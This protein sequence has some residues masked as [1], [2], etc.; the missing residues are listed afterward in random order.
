[1][2]VLIIALA[3]AY[4][5]SESRQCHLLTAYQQRLRRIPYG[6]TLWTVGDACRVNKE[7]L[8][9]FSKNSYTRYMW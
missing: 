1:M 5:E 2:I 9:K 3:V 7:K 8:E 4:T 6:C